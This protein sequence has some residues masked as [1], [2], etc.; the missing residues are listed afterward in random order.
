MET[1]AD[2][3]RRHPSG[4][5][6]TIGFAAA[7]PLHTL[8][9]DQVAEWL[10]VSELQGLSQRQRP[11]VD[12]ALRH[13]R[14]RI[15][16]AP[17]AFRLLTALFTLGDLQATYEVLLGCRLHKASFRRALQAAHLVKPTDEWRRDRRGR[18]AQLYRYAPRRRKGSRR[19]VRFDLLRPG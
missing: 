6:I 3:R 11:L 14:D 4:P 17:I 12:R 13:V 15:D 1:T 19:A 7:S 18:P 9:P 8:P 10:P 2:G 16:V 5:T